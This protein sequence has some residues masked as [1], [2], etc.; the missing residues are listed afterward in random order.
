ME[1]D[2]VRLRAEQGVGVEEE[3]GKKE[4]KKKKNKKK[5]KD[6]RMEKRLGCC[7]LCTFEEREREGMKM[8]RGTQVWSDG[9]LKFF[10]FLFRRRGGAR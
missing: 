3:G 8:W 2:V 7:S 9:M 4:R 10:F 5:K 1:D 6:G